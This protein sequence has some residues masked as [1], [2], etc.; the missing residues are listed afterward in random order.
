MIGKIDKMCLDDIDRE[1]LSMKNLSKENLGTPKTYS[2]ISRLGNN[3]RNWGFRW[4]TFSRL[5]EVSYQKH[6][7]I[8][9]YGSLVRKIKA[10]I[11][12][13]SL[14]VEQIIVLR[15]LSGLGSSFST[16]LTYLTMFN[17]QA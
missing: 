3:L 9:K 4:R 14:T 17:E 13:I 10:E 6:K 8:D 15:L 16:F 5:E 1:F 12:D 11:A 7:S 2:N